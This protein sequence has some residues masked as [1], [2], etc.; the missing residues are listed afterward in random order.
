MRVARSVEELER[1]ERT[2]ALGTFD[3]VH[4]GHRRVIEETLAAGGLPTVVTFDPHPRRVM[5]YGV[6]LLTTLERRLELLAEAGIEET[7]VVEF[8]L[9]FQRIEP[10]EFARRYL[11]PGDP[12]RQW[13]S[14]I[15]PPSRNFIPRFLTTRLVPVIR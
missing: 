8:S 12:L 10:D 6:E 11:G 4:L 1:R 5:G 15:L 14:G 7:L 2:V 13:C 9:E 3:G